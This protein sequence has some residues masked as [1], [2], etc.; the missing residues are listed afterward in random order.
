MR[1][2]RPAP[3]RFRVRHTTSSAFLTPSTPPPHTMFF[4]LLVPQFQRAYVSVAVCAPSRT[5]FLTGLRPD[6]Y[7]VPSF[8][9]ICYTTT[10][11]TCAG[12]GISWW[13][14]RAL[15]L[16]DTPCVACVDDRCVAH[17][18]RFT[19]PPPPPPHVARKFGRSALTSETLQ[20]EKGCR[21]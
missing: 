1:R 3:L 17:A 13:P 11:S 14:S 15:D 20:G 5:A 12:G 2:P 10:C 9:R 8:G 6:T 18:D 4:L 16:N 7:V 21:W 19:L